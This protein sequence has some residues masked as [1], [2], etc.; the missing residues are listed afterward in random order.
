MN[1]TTNA[2]IPSPVIARRAGLLL[3]AT[4]GVAC[5]SNGDAFD[6]GYDDDDPYAN[7][8][9]APTQPESQHFITRIGPEA[10]DID[11]NSVTFTDPATGAVLSDVPQ[12]WSSCWFDWGGD[13]SS[14]D[15]WLTLLLLA[16]GTSGNVVAPGPRWLSVFGPVSRTSA[17]T[18]PAQGTEP[19]DADVDAVALVI[20]VDTDDAAEADAWSGDRGVAWADASGTV[21]F[22]AID[23]EVFP[24]TGA[25]GTYGEDAASA[26]FSLD[27]SGVTLRLLDGR[28]VDV[29]GEVHVS[30]SRDSSGGGGGGG[31]GACPSVAG[32][33]CV[34]MDFSGAQDPTRV[35]DDFKASCALTHDGDVGEYQS[36][37]CPTGG[38]VANCTGATGSL[39]S[40]GEKVPI[41]VVWYPNACGLDLVSTC[42]SLGGNYGTLAGC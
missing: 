29:E 40:T 4:L 39:E 41:E 37:H 33:S 6:D 16:P 5:H 35:E 34:A 3:A 36:G 7:D 42:G 31:W 21:T 8:D 13:L 19:S 12:Q 27:V 25:P 20:Y 14:D 28:E 22:S 23:G 11:M 26:S 2:T 9:G 1:D 24:G 30:G 10:C 38:A 32:E 18:L 15:D 17:T